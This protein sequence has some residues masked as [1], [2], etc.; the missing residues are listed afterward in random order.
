MAK[1]NKCP[2]VSSASWKSLEAQVG[3]DLA[4]ATWM[5]YEGDYPTL[6][7]TTQ[8]RKELN[9][10]AQINESNLFN[11]YKNIRNYNTKNGTAHVVDTTRIGESQRLRVILY[12]N[13][14][15]V[16]AEK[17]RQRDYARKGKIIKFTD[18]F[19]K[20]YPQGI[21]QLETK[22]P[23]G[24]IDTNLA[25]KLSS[26]FP[27][28]KVNF[29]EVEGIAGQANLEALEVLLNPQELMEDTLPHEYAHHYISWFREAPIVQEAIKK[30]GSEEALVQAIGEQIVKQE[31]EAYTW[32]KKFTN[33]VQTLFDNLSTTSKEDLRNMLT[34]AMLTRVDIVTQEELTKKEIL[35]R[36]KQDILNQETKA[37]STK[38]VEEADV[39]KD[40]LEVAVESIHNRVK[41]LEKRGK[42][43]V[44][45]AQKDLLKSLTRQYEESH[46]LEGLAEYLK[47]ASKYLND[48]FGHE[49]HIDAKGKVIPAKEGKLDEYEEAIRN[50]TSKDIISEG[51]TIRQ[52]GNFAASFFHTTTDIMKILDEKKGK[53]SS[54]EVAKQA[55][56]VMMLASAVNGLATRLKSRYATIIVGAVAKFLKPFGW[57]GSLSQLEKKLKDP[58]KDISG[59]QRWVFGMIDAKDDALNLLAVATVNYKE[60]ARLEIVDLSKDLITLKKKLEA[61]GVSTTKWMAAVDSKGIPTG[62]FITER[63]WNTFGKME[64]AFWKTINK[65]YDKLRDDEG[66]LT[67]ENQSNLKK[68]RNRWYNINALSNEAA[69]A[70]ISKKEQELSRE[71]FDTWISLN[72]RSSKD[73]LYNTI[74]KKISTAYT[75][76]AS[77]PLK[78]EYYNT[79]TTL[80][81]DLEKSFPEDFRHTRRIPQLRKDTIERLKAG[82]FKDIANNIAEHY[83]VMEDEDLR[84]VNYGIEDERGNIVNF[85]PIYYTN[86]LD[87]MKHLS[88]DITSS[89][90]EYARMSIE[91]KQLN[92]I[93]DMLEIGSDVFL[94]RK[95]AKTNNRGGAIKVVNSYLS[96]K[97]EKTAQEPGPGNVHAMYRSFLDMI[98]YGKLHKQGYVIFGKDLEKILSSIGGYTAVKQLGLNLFAPIVNV[99]NGKAQMRIE[100]SSGMFFGYDDVVF[101]DKIY[102]S[103]LAGTIADVGQRLPSNK[104]T[105]W[106]EYFDTLESFDSQISNLDLEQKTLFTKMFRT[107]SLFLLS[108]IGEHFM[109]TRTS[110]ALAKQYRFDPKVGRFIKRRDYFQEI[111]DIDNKRV[112]EVKALEKATKDEIKS[113]NNKYNTEIKIA[114]EKLEASWKD[115]THYWDAHEAVNNR[116][117]LKSEFQNEFSEE[118]HHLFTELTRG[119]N[120]AMHGI[121]GTYDRSAMQQ[122]ALGRLAIMFRKW[123][124]PAW[125][126]RFQG[127]KPDYRR[128]GE[129]EGHYLVAFR[130]FELL[131]KDLR[132]AQFSL[133][134]NWSTLTISEKA[135]MRKVFTETA[136]FFAVLTLSS[137][138]VGLSGDDD[139]DWALNMS[140][141]L[142]ARLVTELGALTPS[143]WML[144]EGLKLVETPMAT[145]GIAEDLIPLIQ[146]WNWGEV[147]ERGKY[148]GMTKFQK[149]LIRT[150]PPVKS[151][152]DWAYPEEKISFYLMFR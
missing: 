118:D 91:R 152:H 41:A 12:P 97:T 108:R 77:N 143:P 144:S 60:K 66:N 120:Q 72:A 44:L 87:N 125:N 74:P 25:N 57:T 75:Q 102:F 27:E 46:Y 69:S 138:L 89:I 52:M 150:I 132:S 134:K 20:I 95:V 10:P 117:K 140:A 39:L 128:G 4:W 148:K 38:V 133:Y 49:E 96:K 111:E 26:L 82:D 80:K 92:T 24:V 34:D 139:D 31:G 54:G 16:N 56:E 53:F 1:F 67:A 112:A 55:K 90:L 73:G 64:T 101:S 32:W 50:K 62:D 42:K 43:E 115:L 7:S 79:I 21:L 65:K 48:L 23:V 86:R 106:N 2:N 5:Y 103:E 14:L 29:K 137:V 76:M 130:F 100:A 104:L 13:Y 146:F 105:L 135:S 70:L 142:A 8:L 136:Y 33:W 93:V 17:Q 63:D 22:Q 110:L 94:N 107:S 124:I 28:I 147:L 37:E 19:S 83:K 84:G 51:S 109:H 78:L 119:T 18:A 3:N 59:F 122:Y 126:R 30:W 116:I 35:K 114:K 58:P 81:H 85:V 9:T 129:Y 145:V 61:G 45:T 47:N 71:E 6:K 15:P 113:I 149:T 68:E 11:M 88:M 123:M 151:I 131:T 40:A 98:V 141:Y 121:Y 36:R 99:L 127:K